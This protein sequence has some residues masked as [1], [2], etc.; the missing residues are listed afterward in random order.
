MTYLNITFPDNLK[1]LLDSQAR[2]EKMKRSTL[3]QK[4]VRVYLQM[5]KRQEMTALL[6]EGYGA[7][8]MDAKELLND[9]EKLDHESLKHLD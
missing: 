5:R 1:K 6:V 8:S 7:M 3:I 2:R 4:A 9:F